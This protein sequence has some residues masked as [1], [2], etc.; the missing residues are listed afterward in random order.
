[1]LEMAHELFRLGKRKNKTVWNNGDYLSMNEKNRKNTNDGEAA[2]DR[3]FEESLGHLEKIVESM[4]QGELTLEET[5]KYY[6]EGMKLAKFCSEKLGEAEKRI[7]VLSGTDE[8]GN[9]AWQPL[10]PPGSNN[11]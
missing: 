8:Q 4:E 11:E 6:E 9:P 1:M 5:L 7:Q 3:K 10:T 2:E